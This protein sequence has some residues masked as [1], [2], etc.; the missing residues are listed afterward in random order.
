MQIKIASK[1]KAPK[2][3]QSIYQ[4]KIEPYHGDAD[5]YKTSKFLVEPEKIEQIMLEILFVDN[6]FDSGRGG[7]RTMYDQLSYFNSSEIKTEGY[8]DWLDDFPYDSD[9]EQNY[10]IDTYTITYFDANYLEYDV[11]VSKI[12]NVIKDIKK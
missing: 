6:Q 5:G 8:F 9:A 2:K 3:P 11:K 4:I 10:T 7:C 1:P 12:E